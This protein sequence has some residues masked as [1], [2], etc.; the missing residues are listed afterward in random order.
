MDWTFGTF[1]WSTVVFFFWFAV[2]WMFVGI[3]ADI[4]RRDDLSGW[5][6]AGWIFLIVA[7]PFLG[8]LIYVIARPRTASTG[9]YYAAPTASMNGHGSRSPAEEISK[10]SALYESG[11]ITQAEYEQL[12]AR[13]LA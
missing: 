5:G 1:L 9:A 10:A 8:I 13:A 11:K 4:F 6:R 12:K 3:F 7:L 2:I